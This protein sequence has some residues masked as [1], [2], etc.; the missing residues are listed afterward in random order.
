MQKIIRFF[1][2]LALALPGVCVAA[3]PAP[4]TPPG[5]TNPMMED[6]VDSTD[7]Y[8]IPLDSSEE[9][10]D[11]EEGSLE[12]LQ[13]KEQQKKAKPSVTQQQSMSPKKPS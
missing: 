1:S 13:K 12:A 7:T 2:V 4:K 3:A 5:S 9:E 6:Q 8:A 11:Q 10:E